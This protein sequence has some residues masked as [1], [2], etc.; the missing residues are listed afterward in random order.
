LTIKSKL[1]PLWKK[2]PRRLRRFGVVLAQPR[3]TVTAGVVLYDS[4]GRILLLRHRYRP[5]SGWG[6]PGG[7]LNPSEQPEAAA[8]RELK[9]ELGIDVGDL[10]LA[11]VRTLT[12]IRQVENVFTGRFDGEIAAVNDEV[13]EFGWFGR[14]ELPEELPTDQHSLI[15]RA[16]REDAKTAKKN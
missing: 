1:A 10:G 16:S 2:L 15:E 14:E 5:G 8:R 3:F 12:T 11:F 4:Q 7:F 6:I 13:L 9:E